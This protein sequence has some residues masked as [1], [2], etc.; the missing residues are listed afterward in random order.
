MKKTNFT[1]SLAKLKMIWL[2]AVFFLFAGGIIH[3]QA[4]D[5]TCAMACNSWTQISLDEECEATIVPSMLLNGEETSCE[6]IDDGVYTVYVKY[7]GQVIDGSP[8]VGEEWIGYT[9]KAQITHNDSGNSCWGDIYIE[10]KLPPDITCNDVTI[11]CFEEDTY[12]PDAVDA[13]DGPVVPILIN[14]YPVDEGPCDVEEDEV[15]VLMRVYVAADSKGNVSDPC[16]V[17]VTLDR[18]DITAVTCPP[19][20]D[21]APGDNEAILCND[22]YYTE[23]DGEM[24]LDPYEYGVPQYNGYDLWPNPTFK[25]GLSVTFEDIELPTINCVRKIMRI[26]TVREWYCTDEFNAPMCGPLNA[27]IFEIVDE[28]D[29]EIEADYD[30]EVS[31]NG[32]TCEMNVH[33]PPPVNLDD[34]CFGVLHVDVLIDIEDEE[35]PDIFI[36]NF[37]YEDGQYVILPD[38]EHLVTYTAYDECHNSSSDDLTVTVKDNTPPVVVCDEFTVISVTLDGQAEVH[39]NVFDD[40]SYDDCH[41]KQ[42]LVRRMDDG[43][44]DCETPK[45][46]GFDKIGTYNGHYYYLSHYKFKGNKAHKI[47]EAMG[48]YVV[49]FNS[50]GEESDVTNAVRAYT[51]DSYWIGLTDAADEGNFKWADGTYPFGI[52]IASTSS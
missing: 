45:F 40:G 33:I 4:Q 3:V 21:L 18:I 27:Q 15:K 8:D 20:Y 32:Y 48:G 12:V 1:Y 17:K 49:S 37:D 28:I 30:F 43:C 6:M 31:T 11:D 35:V 7:Q 36:P 41:L 2:S 38:G 23:I 52:S 10:D 39:A 42:L 22:V 46:D 14:E 24:V 13:C 16:T 25:C 47:A 51:D 34:E 5:E 50:P 26:W 19:S 29:P 44:P 9:L